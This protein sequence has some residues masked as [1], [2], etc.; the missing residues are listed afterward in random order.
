[1]VMNHLDVY[2]LSHIRETDDLGLSE[3]LDGD[4]V[5]LIEWGDTIRSALPRDY[6]QVTL[7]LGDSSPNDCA[8]GDVTPRDLSSDDR[9]DRNPSLE[10][11]SSDDPANEVRRIDLLVR[12]S[13]WRPRLAALRRVLEPWM[14]SNAA[15]PSDQSAPAPTDRAV[16]DGSHRESRPC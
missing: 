7:A 10:D 6:L 13:S 14:T 3:L 5:T 4:S 8:D 2:R 16:D 15:A 9:V 12:G 11:P 1:M